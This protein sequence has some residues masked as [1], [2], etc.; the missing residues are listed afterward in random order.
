MNISNRQPSGRKYLDPVGPDEREIVMDANT[1]NNIVKNAVQAA[2]EAA[3]QSWMTNQMS[4]TKQSSNQT[5]SG[6][7]HDKLTQ[8]VA[9]LDVLQDRLQ[10]IE[11]Q[12]IS[13]ASDKT[14]SEIIQKKLKEVD[15]RMIQME[16]ASNNQQNPLLDKK[17]QS[18]SERLLALESAVE[19]EHETSLQVLDVL[20]N[21]KLGHKR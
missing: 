6:A 21:K 4:P 19:S 20:L 12:M 2:L 1:L 15:N 3:H 10:N 8:I 17:L 9:R 5:T 7:D 13:H 18:L 14:S 16:L 11:A